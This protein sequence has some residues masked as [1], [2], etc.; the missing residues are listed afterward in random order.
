MRFLGECGAL[1]DEAERERRCA[2]WD[3]AGKRARGEAGEEYMNSMRTMK[4]KRPFL[5]GEGYLGMGPREAREGDVVVVFCGGRIPFVLRPSSGEG[6]D[7]YTFVGEA[8]CDGVMDGE[9]IGAREW[10]EFYIE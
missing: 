3:L 7:V 1:P 4:G 2:E 5:T 8:Y 6:S 10:V 9:V